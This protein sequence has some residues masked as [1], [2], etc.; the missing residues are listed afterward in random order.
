MMSNGAARAFDKTAP[1]AVAL[2][3]AGLSEEQIVQDN[4]TA[5]VSLPQDAVNAIMAAQQRR[6][7][8]WRKQLAGVAKVALA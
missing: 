3:E 7:G 4:W 6:R 5:L 2:L 1:L 8:R